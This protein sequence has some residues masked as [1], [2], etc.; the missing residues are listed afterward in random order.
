M[1]GRGRTGRER[2]RI[3]HIEAVLVQGLAAIATGTAGV[4]A[5]LLLIAA[6]TDAPWWN[7]HRIPRLSER[8]HSLG[9]TT[10]D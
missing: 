9:R 1:G 4:L 8:G 7:R 5:G 2:R 10:T 6:L 3:G